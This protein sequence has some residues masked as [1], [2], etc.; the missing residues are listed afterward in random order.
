MKWF[1]KGK[2][3]SL[4]GKEAQYAKYLFN[5]MGP[6]TPSG[7]RYLGLVNEATGEARVFLFGAN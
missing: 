7:L 1:E 2:K 5:I 4:R 3:F 6:C